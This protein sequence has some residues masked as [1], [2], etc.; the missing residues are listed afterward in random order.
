M[1]A[2][3]RL[4]L[5]E[6]DASA[7][8][9]MLDRVIAEVAAEYEEHL[10]PAIDRVW[11]D[12][13]GDIGRDLRVWVRRLAA[14]GASSRR[15]RLGAGLLRVRV[16]PARRRRPRR[17]ER[18]RPGADRRPFQ[19]A[20]IGRSDRG[21]ARGGTARCAIS[22]S[23]TTRPGKNRTDL[24][25]G[26]RR[27]RDPAAGALQPGDRAGARRRRSQSGRLFYCTVGRR[28][29][30]SRDPAQRD[31]P[32]RRPRG[33][34]DRRSRDRARLPPAGPRRRAP[35]PGATS[36][37]CAAPT[38]PAASRNKAPEKLGDLD[39]A[40]GEAMTTPSPL[41]TRRRAHAIATALDDTLVVEAAAGTGK[42]TELVEPDRPDPGERTRRGARRLSRSRLPRRPPAS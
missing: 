6:K 9:A 14:A 5:A 42:T 32:S 15:R 28:V 33:A 18:A 1:Q 40:E 13:I 41:P 27:R 24:E 10:A 3:G 17:R 12:E 25:D 23:P 38:R 35:A 2:D 16:R 39:G 30:R 29:R 37:R 20:R 36:C 7:A 8:L 11:R 22:A 21:E 26:D 34:R 31:Q 19:A 4:P